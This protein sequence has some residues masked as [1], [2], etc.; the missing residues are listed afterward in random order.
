[1]LERIIVQS[2]TTNHLRG[3]YI[4]PRRVILAVRVRLLHDMPLEVR[5]EARPRKFHAKV[6]E[7]PKTWDKTAPEGMP[8]EPTLPFLG[9]YH[10][11]GPIYFSRGVG[12]SSNLQIWHK[13]IER[14]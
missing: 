6:A 12:T 5:H 1:M 14:S 9:I 11:P 13:Y 10:P 7:D 8:A 4:G 2:L 3:I